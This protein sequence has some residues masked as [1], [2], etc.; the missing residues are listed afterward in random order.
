MANKYMKKCS[1]SLLIEEMQLK[2]TMRYH[3]IPTRMAIIKIINKQKTTSVTEDVEK[4]VPSYFADGDL[5]W[6]RHCGKQCGSS[7]KS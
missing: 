5:K 6:C 4:L 1:T 7:S 2:T 3:F